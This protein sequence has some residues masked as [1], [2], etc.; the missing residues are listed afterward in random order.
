MVFT[1]SISHSRERTV[2]TQRETETEVIIQKAQGKVLED[3]AK[4]TTAET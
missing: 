2:S 3:V 4:K 1:E